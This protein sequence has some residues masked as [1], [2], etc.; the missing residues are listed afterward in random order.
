MEVSIIITR[1]VV[2]RLIQQE[3]KGEVAHIICF[4]GTSN[5]LTHYSHSTLTSS[6]LSVA[7]A[8]QIRLVNGLRVAA[9]EFLNLKPV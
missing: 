6:L 3:A 5:T 9:I 2:K 1:G 4:I 7:N 8:A